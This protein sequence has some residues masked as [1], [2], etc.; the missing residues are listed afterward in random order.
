[1]KS[2]KVAA[3]VLNQIPLDWDGNKRRIL[4]AVDEARRQGS[5]LLCLPELCITGYGCEDVFLS[6]SLW[7]AAESV[8]LEIA[9][10]CRGMVVALGLPIWHGGS[11][12][13]T[14]ALVVDG[15]VAGLVGKQNLAGEGIHYEQRWFA[16]WPAGL[17]SR[18]TIA[19]L[20]LPI[21]DLV[22]E[23]S[24]FRIGFEICR[25]A[26][27]ASRPGTDLTRHAVDV[28]LNPSASHFAFGKHATRQRFVLE[29][30]RAFH[31]GYV[32]TNLLGNES[33]RAIFDGDAMIASNG[34]MLAKCARFSFD[35][36]QVISAA[37]DIE[38]ARMLRAQWGGGQPEAG[39]DGRVVRLPFRLD[40]S[41][42]E[43]TVVDEPIWE[44]SEELKYEEFTRAVSLGLFDYLRKSRAQG[45]VVSLS[46]G[47]DS[48]A[49]SL[50]CRFAIELAV[51]ELGA[52][53]LA[54]RLGH[55]ADLP[56]SSDPGDW[57]ARLLTCVYQAT[58]NNTQTTRDAARLVA[59]EIGAQFFEVEIDAIVN[60]YVAAGE[61]SLGRELT[62]QEDDAALQNIQ[63]RTRAPLV[64]LFANLRKSV[65]LCTSNRSEAAVG[66]ATMDGDTAGG[67]CPIA[68]IDKS[69]LRRWLRWLELH[70][71]TDGAPLTF[72]EAVT[73]QAP[74]AELRPPQAGQTDEGDL[75]PYDVLADIERAAIRDRRAPVEVFVELLPV[76]RDHYS[77]EQ[78]RTWVGRFFRLWARS[79]WKRERFAP[80]FH[81]DDQN[82]DP[83]T[84]CRFPILSGG[85]E[86]ELRELDVLD[87]AAD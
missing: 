87:I 49:T 4:G 8:L 81:V 9:E 42:W 34:K 64:W 15:Q 69:F 79:Q 16:P 58:A 30:S 23:L 86:R 31:V 72:L 40:A 55:I 20:D 35:D 57:M 6:S 26:W 74:T 85:F 5:Q 52:D 28:I 54:E 59:T 21:G 1:M 3:A 36:F 27:V 7:R 75:M 32:Y 51:R 73:E 19:G 17:V 10:E 68:G 2:V 50:L 67:L 29:G 82:L 63:A 33:G 14:A 61:A 18:A 48:T 56:D 80:S 66:Y 25:D 65:L 37:F 60:A 13:N 83:K 71:Y 12:Y 47:A 78:L 41:P 46:G 38:E 77:A 70:G 43:P 44:Q 39:D 76:W 53:R 11:L 24:G 84:W 45:Y 62:W 22:F